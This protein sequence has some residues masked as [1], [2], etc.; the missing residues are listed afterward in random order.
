MQT[1][2][3]SLV[4]WA[5]FSVAL[6]AA[7][8]LHEGSPP[9][10]PCVFLRISSALSA[11]IWDLFLT[12]ASQSDQLLPC[13]YF[14]AKSTPWEWKGDPEP[15]WFSLSIWFVVLVGAIWR[16]SSPCLTLA[17]QTGVMQ[18]ISGNIVPIF[19]MIFGNFHMAFRHFHLKYGCV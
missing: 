2:A 19:L 4:P 13:H 16:A 14:H 1:L 6:S 5:I 9:S 3:A 10:D 7:K 15:P 11:H 8:D 17:R 12:L 18:C